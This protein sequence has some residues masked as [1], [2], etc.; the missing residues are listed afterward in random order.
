MVNQ[1]QKQQIINSVRNEDPNKIMA[2]IKNIGKFREMYNRACRK[3]QILIIKNA[4]RPMDEY[5]ERCRN[6]FQS[7]WEN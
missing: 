2:A 3:C 7:I 1:K 5:C 6:M 4:K